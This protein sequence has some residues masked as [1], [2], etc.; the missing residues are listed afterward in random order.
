MIICIQIE[1]FMPYFALIILYYH[2]KIASYQRALSSY[3]SSP[4][5]IDDKKMGEGGEFHSHDCYSRPFIILQITIVDGRPCPIKVITP[6]S[7]LLVFHFCKSSMLWY[8]L[9]TFYPLVLLLIS[10][11]MLLSFFFISLYLL[12]YVYQIEDWLRS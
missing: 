11:Y 1:C 9:K 7:S 12:G 2:V 6:P 5:I 3:F 10:S 8:L 4:R